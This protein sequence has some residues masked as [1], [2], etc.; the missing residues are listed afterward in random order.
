VRFIGRQICD[1]GA[2]VPQVKDRAQAEKKPREIAIPLHVDTS[3]LMHWL[4]HDLNWQN[5][6][7]A[8]T[9]GWFEA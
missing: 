4:L 7:V 1:A 2:D 5:T 6:Q 3:C 9:T 8:R